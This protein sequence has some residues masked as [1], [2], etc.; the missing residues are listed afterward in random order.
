MLDCFRTGTSA[1][2]SSLGPS[3]VRTVF[4]HFSGL[5]QPLR[6]RSRSGV[7]WVNHEQDN[8][9]L[10]TAYKVV[11]DGSNVATEGRTRPSLAQLDEAVRSFIEEHPSADVLVI[12]DSSFP[13]RI[14]PAD[15]AVFEEAFLAGE[16]ITPPAG[17]VGRGDAFILKVA[18][19]L[20]ATVFS[21]DSFQEFHGTYEWLFE[22]GRLIGGK[23][24][25]GLGWVF[26]PRVPVRGQK[27]REA[28]REAKRQTVRV[29]SPEAMRPMPVPKTPPPF[30][31]KGGDDGAGRD[32]GAESGD[33]RRRKKR[34]G[35]RDDARSSSGEVMFDE[36]SVD[37]VTL[38]D[39][40]GGS[41]RSDDAGSRTRKRRGRG[42]GEG[43][44][45][46]LVA[47]AVN[48][49]G[50]FLT[51]IAS[52]LPGSAVD[53]VVDDYSSHG[54]YVT[55]GGARCY[56]P[57]SGL[58]EPTP[59]S[60]KEVVRRGETRNFIVKAF[61][62]ARRG[63]EL[64]LIGSPSAGGVGG[65][66]RSSAAAPAGANT[67]NAKPMKARAK[68]SAATSARRGTGSAPGVAAEIAVAEASPAKRGA[69]KSAA[70]VLSPKSAPKPVAKP[71]AKKGSAKPKAS[72]KAPAQ[73]L[74]E[75]DIKTAAPS[76]KPVAKKVVAKKAL[77]KKAPVKKAP[78]KKV[79]G[80]SAPATKTTGR[81]ERST[82][83]TATALTAASPVVAP[84]H[85]AP[86]PKKAAA[87]K[88]SPA[89]PTSESSRPK[90]KNASPASRTAPRKAAVKKATAE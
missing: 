49:P 24:I 16:I 63:I 76:G 43:P 6:D 25:P 61:D 85:G 71:V 28:V 72:A 55:A 22:K 69:R 52:N 4:A 86:A 57:L 29:G 56:V 30:L 90:P 58:A 74:S 54:F 75:G 38:T 2:S 73:P 18:D 27:S 82:K 37:R 89:S 64:A 7:Q 80:A 15:V 8:P 45:A 32:G 50:V 36:S 59:R 87:K 62:A 78:V 19:K 35:G 34:R 26:T 81:K 77:V 88:T 53:G 84:T 1:Q 20:G 42:R 65:A 17:T 70:P 9:H 39:D 23:P 79:A 10:M 46:E 48:E 14:D 60:A 13:N 66:A 40:A 83:V 21:N 5:H 47:L 12:V 44:Q 11:V 31:T 3:A 41:G 33:R 67:S 51:F 68:K